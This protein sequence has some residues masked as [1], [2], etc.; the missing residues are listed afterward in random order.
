MKKITTSA[1]MILV[2]FATYAQNVPEDSKTIIDRDFM[3]EL[4]TESG[5]LLGIFIF[6]TFIL[7]IVRTALDSR[8]KNKLIDKGASENIVSQL[9]QP[10]KTD[11]KLEPLKWFSILAGIGLGLALI[12]AFQPLGIHSLAI[13]AFSLAAGFLAYY[14]FTRKVEK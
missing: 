14:F 5:I 10:L 12:D 3:K 8:L 6:T 2:S 11:S 9:L 1:I 4:L 7:T 13:M